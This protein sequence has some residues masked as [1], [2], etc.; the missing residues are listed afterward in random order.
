MGLDLYSICLSQSPSGDLSILD[1][2]TIF[3]IGSI[4]KTFTYA[5]MIK[6]LDEH[7]IRIISSIRSSLPQNLLARNP[8]LGKITWKQLA[9]HTSGLSNLPYSL[10]DKATLTGTFGAILAEHLL[11]NP[12]EYFSKDHVFE[13]LASAT[14]DEKSPSEFRYSNLG[15]GLLGL[16]LS[17]M[18]GES[19]QEL[20]ENKV[21]SPLNMGSTTAGTAVHQDRAI[22]GYAQYRKFGPIVVTAQVA[23]WIFHDVMAGAGA[24]SAPLADMI[25]Y[26]RYSIKEYERPYFNNPDHT[27]SLGDK[28]TAIVNL[29]WFAAPLPDES[30]GDVVFHNGRT[31]GFNSFLGFSNIKQVGIVILTNGTRDVTPLGAGLVGLLIDESMNEEPTDEGS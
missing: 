15:V 16:L 14:Q 21:L 12:Y 18:E 5:A 28:D 3:E 2:T 10:S 19:Y 22:A 29:G 1:D 6:V 24:I 31:G 27:A 23:P 30:K 13:Y 17:E 25:T 20:I 7:N 8:G 11:N 4:T 26:L 9:T